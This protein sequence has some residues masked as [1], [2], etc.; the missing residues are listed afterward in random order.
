MKQPLTNIQYAEALE[1]IAAF[2]RANPEMPQMGNLQKYFVDRQ[3]FL[4]AVK[5]LSAGG[6]VTKSADSPRDSEWCY[7]RARRDF[8]GL[9][10]ELRI[11]RSQVCRL[12]EPARPAV[13]ECP[14]SLLEEA[15]E[16]EER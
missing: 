13:Y 2:Y 9:A 12:V 15:A 7:F 14:D 5:A 8:Q 4:S 10:V 6:M 1:A 3:D 11:D 16:F